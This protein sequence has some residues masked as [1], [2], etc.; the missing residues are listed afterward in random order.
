MAKAEFRHCL[1]F[2]ETMEKESSLDIK[3]ELKEFV[4]RLGEVQRECRIPN[5]YY[6][7]IVKGLEMLGCISVSERGAWGN[8][9]RVYLI[10]PPGEDEW[11]AHRA[12][13]EGPKGGNLWE[14]VEQRVQKIE[15]QLGGVENV[16]NG[17][18]EL[19]RQIQNLQVKI[20]AIER[21]YG[22]ENESTK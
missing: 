21:K 1:N 4:G 5:A 6:S 18:A 17:L 15:K 11:T 7:A 16:V 19:E 13:T 12:L 3:T 8:P 9:S 10:R 20:D 22:I 2:Y 14:K